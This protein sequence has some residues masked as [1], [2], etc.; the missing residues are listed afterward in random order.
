MK[1]AVGGPLGK[2]FGRW[3]ARKYLVRVIADN[4]KMTNVIA[5]IDLYP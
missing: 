1:G 3:L 5:S 2:F 4:P